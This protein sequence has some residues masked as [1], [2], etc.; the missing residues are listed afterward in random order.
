MIITWSALTQEGAVLI[1]GARRVV[2]TLIIGYVTRIKHYVTET[3]CS[4]RR[5]QATKIIPENRIFNIVITK[6]G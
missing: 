2:T 3:S 4:K 6:G 5:A 1:G